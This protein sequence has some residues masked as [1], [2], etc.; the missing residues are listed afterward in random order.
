MT[1]E[2]TAEQRETLCA[3]LED[4]TCR[5]ED[6]HPELAEKLERLRRTLWRSGGARVTADIWVAKWC[7]CAE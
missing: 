7:D 3:L 1:I 6:R 4:E 5:C 2:I